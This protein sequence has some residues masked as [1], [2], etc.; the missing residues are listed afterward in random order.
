M[1]KRGTFPD[2][3]NLGQREVSPHIKKGVVD[4]YIYQVDA[5]TDRIFTGN[6]AGV[7]ILD[8]PM[9]ERWMRNVAMEMN[10]SETAFLQR[11]ED[12][13][14]LRWFTPEVE[15][16][17]CGHATLASAFV[18]WKTGIL[19]PDETARFHTLS[20]LLTAVKRPDGIELDFPAKIETQVP[21][22]ERMVEALGADPLYV[23]CN[24]M[25]YLVELKSE[26][27]VRRLNPDFNALGRVETRGVMVTAAADSDEYDF[28]SRFFVP[29][30]GVNEDPVT[31][32]AH[33]CL[34]PYWMK[35]LGKNV[36]K[37]WQASKRG[38]GMIVKVEGG[39][40]KLVG[41]AAMVFRADM[42]EV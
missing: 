42:P 7:C 4:M 15:V 13:F 22:P 24:K 31:G 2:P 5:F 33:C 32:S 17:L 40:V 23:G 10:L 26:S 35:K 8:K 38:G 11:Q 21:P 29:S 28:V 25:D 20:G 37:A 12:G 1:I 9:D 18:L 39:R 16:E 6:P 34:G 41:Q 3:G 14:R 30:C 19:R 27:G 36:L